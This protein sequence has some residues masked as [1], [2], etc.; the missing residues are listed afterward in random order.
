MLAQDQPSKKSKRALRPSATSG[1]SLK[2]PIR[3]NKRVV[4]IKGFDPA[5]DQETYGERSGPSSSFNKKASKHQKKEK[6]KEKERPARVSSKQPRKPP[7]FKDYNGQ[8]DDRFMIDEEDDPDDERND[9]Y[10]IKSTVLDQM[11]YGFFGLVPYVDAD[12]RPD[13]L[14]QLL[15]QMIDPNPLGETLMRW[16]SSLMAVFALAAAICAVIPKFALELIVMKHQV[17][18]DYSPLI[19]SVGPIH[20]MDLVRFILWLLF[21]LNVM[22]ALSAWGWPEFLSS[23]ALFCRKMN[24]VLWLTS[25]LIIPWSAMVMALVSGLSNVSALV[26]IVAMNGCAY[27]LMASCEFVSFYMR[28]RSFAAH[29]E[30]RWFDSVI[31]SA[32]PLLIGSGLFFVSWC[33]IIYTVSYAAVPTWAL[34][35][36]SFAFSFHSLLILFNLVARFPWPMYTPSSSVYT[37]LSLLGMLTNTLGTV[38]PL[39]VITFSN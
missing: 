31:T 28:T 29:I 21:V 22:D 25:V 32:L 7:T 35:S 4:E 14:M 1:S 9:L 26:L 18:A 20:V 33:I 30:L 37:F 39:L 23:A 11:K 8:N 19:E 38:V 24:P 3:K 27:L 34:V 12:F 36:C 5:F 17:G 16:T 15:L 10:I 2:K 13:N 6:E